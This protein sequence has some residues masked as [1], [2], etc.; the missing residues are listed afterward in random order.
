[1]NPDYI[2]I[3]MIKL[4]LSNIDHDPKGALEFLETAPDVEYRHDYQCFFIKRDTPT[5][6]WLALMYGELFE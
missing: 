6:S 4:L 1:M 2:R 5:H 3:D